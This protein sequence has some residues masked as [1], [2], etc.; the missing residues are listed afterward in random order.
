MDRLMGLDENIS[1]FC[2]HGTVAM[3]IDDKGVHATG[4]RKTQRSYSMHHL[5]SD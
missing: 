1:L 5:M 2:P 3:M 4:S